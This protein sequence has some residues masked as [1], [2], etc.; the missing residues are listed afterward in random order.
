M[1]GENLI[2]LLQVHEDIYAATFR[3]FVEKVKQLIIVQEEQIDKLVRQNCDLEARI[4]GFVE[5]N[6]A[7]QCIVMSVID[8]VFK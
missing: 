2:Q 6:T 7:F 8:S 4:L 1:G 3:Q 5:D